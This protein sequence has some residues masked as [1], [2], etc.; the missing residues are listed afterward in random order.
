M[1]LSLFLNSL[2]KNQN[3]LP[4]GYF[5]FLL[6]TKIIRKT[7]KIAKITVTNMMPRFHFIVLSSHVLSESLSRSARSV[8]LLRSEILPI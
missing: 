4:G 3:K 5:A 2:S 7:V 1:V 6:N 8:P